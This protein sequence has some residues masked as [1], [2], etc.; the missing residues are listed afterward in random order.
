LTS[1]E[2]YV[3]VPADILACVTETDPI[4]ERVRSLAPS[5]ARVLVTGG[6]GFIGTNLVGFLRASGVQAV[7]NIDIAR[8][9]NEEHAAMWTRLDIRDAS[10]LTDV[11][12]TFQPDA[13][14]HLGART[15]L[16]GSQL[17][18]Y[19]ANTTGTSNVIAALL[20]LDRPSRA[21]FASSR[22][23]CHIDYQPKAEDDYAP[24]TT[25]G[26]SKVETER[27]VRREAGELGWVM[28]RPTS[29]WGP[30]FATPYRD[31]FEAIDHRRY[32]HPSGVR[33]KK[34]FGFVGNTVYELD[35]LMFGGGLEQLSHR[36]IYLA[37]Y[38]PLDV[39][40]WAILIADQMRRRRPPS[41]PQPVL[42]M[43]A[44]AGDFA[45]RLGMREPPLTSFR[46]HNLVTEMTYDTDP[47]EEVVGDLP[48]SLE[49]GV[50]ITVDW[51]RSHGRAV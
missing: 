32:A 29:I 38:P 51:L 21:V 13:V 42:R 4:A 43:G 41:I 9:R 45:Q 7:L 16:H 30:W 48:F 24:T 50:A 47:L 6:S 18:Q 27:I 17:A 5:G 19:D 22:L 14:F 15:D 28:V 3:R 12:A 2:V 46:L 23:V 44:I 11:V 37:D 35:R 26:E 33:V 10:A 25:Y 36:T 40:R 39:L 49:D 1:R 8:P 34:S 20:A 31:F